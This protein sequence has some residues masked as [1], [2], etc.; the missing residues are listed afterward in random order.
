MGVPTVGGELWFDACYA[1]TPLVNAMCVGV[2]SIDRLQRAAAA[3]V[4]NHLLL[5][6]ADT[7]CDG[8]N[9][10][11][12]ASVEL[13]AT[14]LDRR[15][16][17]QVG[18]PFFEKCLLEACQELISVPGVVAIQDLGAAGLS[19][20][21]AECAARGGL[22]ARLDIAQVPRRDEGMNA[23]QVM[24]SES[25][26][27]M[28]LVVES[29]A[30]DAVRNIFQR[31]ELTVARIGEVTDDG[32]LTVMD[33]EWVAAQLPIDL[34]VEGAPTPPNL[35]GEAPRPQASKGAPPPPLLPSPTGGEE[36]MAWSRLLVRL[37]DRPNLCN[38]RPIFRQYDH[39]VGNATVVPPGGDAAVLRINGTPAG[40]A[41]TLDSNSR[42]CRLDPY[43]GAQIAVCEA[44]RNLLATGARPLAVTDCLNFGNPERPE[45]Y[46]Q[47]EQVVAG[48][49][50]ACR[51]LEL[52]VV[53]GNVSL[54][55][56]S[57]QGAI[58]PTPV[59]G[60]IGLLED[61]QKC[62]KAGFQA[63]GDFAVLIGETRNQLGGSEYSELIG[64][65]SNSGPPVVDLAHEIRLREFMLSAV[66]AGLLSSAHDVAEGGLLVALAESCLLGRRGIGGATWSVPEGMSL[67]S[68]F[69]SES[70]G[71]MI[72]SVHPRSMPELQSLARVHQLELS[73]L[74]L[75][76][77][78]RIE[79]RGQVEVSLSELEQA[80]EGGGERAD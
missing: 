16:V 24:L 40:L 11:A 18:N 77:G 66:A 57:P 53:S 2:V 12:F 61:Y 9:A 71:R 26:E 45:V 15:P 56:E 44:A 70:Q 27:R 68:L 67:E 38:R 59:I 34:L 64:S 80:W 21:V 73:L 25:Q 29:E 74:G 20:A 60:M 58:D 50:H 3:G 19:S 52:P 47:L 49:S 41:V 51:V 76:G 22:G 5:V 46:W 33:G 78:E 17:V 72:V 39:M 65:T 42:Y 43:L 13:D 36:S 6:G 1:G 10:A 23:Y 35:R 7:G 55:N 48:I 79:I 31:W 8:I 4:G 30:I 32:Q 37:L 69:F 28:L 54:Y 14:S 62:L 63:D 75:I